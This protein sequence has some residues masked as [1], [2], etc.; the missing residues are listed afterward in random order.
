ME[1]VWIYIKYRVIRE[2]MHREENRILLLS[3]CKITMDKVNVIHMHASHYSVIR[4]NNFHSNINDIHNL[5]N[6]SSFTAK[7]GAFFSSRRVLTMSAIT[8]IS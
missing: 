6:T 4:L 3:L 1:A 7:A 8:C 2:C 5:I